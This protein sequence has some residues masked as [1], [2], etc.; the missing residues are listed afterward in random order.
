[1]AEWWDSEYI[2]DALSSLELMSL[3]SNVYCIPNFWTIVISVVTVL[4]GNV[5]VLSPNCFLVALGKKLYSIQNMLM[6]STVLVLFNNR[7][8]SQ[9]P[10]S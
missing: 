10:Q 6:F 8:R 5:S 7:A 9:L 2:T 4:I 3:I 1:M